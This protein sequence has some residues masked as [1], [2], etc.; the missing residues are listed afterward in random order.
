[1]GR[2]PPPADETEP[3]D[4]AVEEETRPERGRL[5]RTSEMLEL[6]SPLVAMLV[7]LGSALLKLAVERLPTLQPIGVVLVAFLS[8]LAAS[9]LVQ[10][11][12]FWRDLGTPSARAEFLRTLSFAILLLGV[13]VAGMLARYFWELFQ[14]GRSL[15]DADPSVLVLPMLVSLM[16]FYP[17]WTRVRGSTRSFFV[18]VAAFQNGFFWQALLSGVTPFAAA[19]PY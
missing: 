8:F 18:V 2:K 13:T 15:A 11:L 10:L 14:A 12:L 5:A 7:T 17:L 4:D 16:V 9:A 1:L 6:A 19:R 3:G